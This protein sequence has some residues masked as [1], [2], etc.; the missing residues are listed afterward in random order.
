MRKSTNL[1]F[2][3]A[4]FLS[5]I[6][7]LGLLDHVPPAGFCFMVAWPFLIGWSALTRPTPRNERWLV[8]GI[9]VIFLAVALILPLQNVRPADDTAK[10]IFTHPAFVV[11]LW[12]GWLWL[13]YRARRREKGV[14]GH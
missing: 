4:V 1:R 5:T 8:I 13:I 10:R 6:G 14:V 7:G 3:A 2:T 12:V 11:P 9:V